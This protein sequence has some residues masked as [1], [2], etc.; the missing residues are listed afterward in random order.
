MSTAGAYPTTATGVLESTVNRK[1]KLRRVIQPMLIRGASLIT[2]LVLWQLASANKWNLIVNFENVPAPTAVWAA[3]GNLV[4]SPKFQTHL[5]SSIGRVFAGFGS[6]TMLAI[7][8]GMAVGRSRL[9]SNVLMPSLELLRPIPAVAWIPL[10]VLM[11]PNPEE[12]MVYITFV[13]AFYP[14]LLNTIQ[15]VASIDP[16]LTF[17][18]LTLGAPRLRVFSEVIVPGA[19]PSIVT[20][21]SIGMGNAWF[22]LVTAEMVAGQFGIGYYT[23]ESYTLQKYPDIVLGMITIGVLGMLSSWL[24]KRIAWHFLPWAKLEG[25]R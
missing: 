10:A 20:G 18:S 9:A 22:S 17:A 23:W 25:N 11:F 6:A 19:M 13:G 2:C 4:Q 8:I 3:A 15:G 12:S 5:V 1:I 21:L 16:K 24:I 7:A 14:I